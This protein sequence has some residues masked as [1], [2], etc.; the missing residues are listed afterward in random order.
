MKRR[1]FVGVIGNTSLCFLAGS[2][3]LFAND[4]KK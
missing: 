2:L 1:Q 3:P 4:S